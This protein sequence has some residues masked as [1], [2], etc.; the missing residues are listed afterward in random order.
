MATKTENIQIILRKHPRIMDHLTRYQWTIK[1]GHPNQ[2]NIIKQFRQAIGQ[3]P[4]TIICEVDKTQ[5][6]LKM[7]TRNI[8]NA[9]PHQQHVIKLRIP[10]LVQ[11]MTPSAEETNEPNSTENEQ[12][13]DCSGSMKNYTSSDE[14]LTE[15][16]MEETMAMVIDWI[17]RGWYTP[18]RA[19]PFLSV[20]N[21]EESVPNQ[22]QPLTAQSA[23][24]SCHARGRNMIR[25]TQKDKNKTH[26]VQKE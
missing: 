26:P 8:P 13:S 7:M 14:V 24:Q 19:I 16:E 6:Q 17:Q 22:D 18:Q 21:N 9:P 5:S 25:R 10:K 1:D 4:E 3:C 15:F 11:L 20:S 12:K 2:L 23:G